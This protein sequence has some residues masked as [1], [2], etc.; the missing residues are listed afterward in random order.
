[1]ATGTKQRLKDLRTE[2]LSVAGKYGVREVKVFGS[3]VRGED[4]EGSDI[5]F[6]VEFSTPPTLVQYVGLQEELQRL[7]GRNVDI[8]TPTSLHWFIREKVLQ[9][10]EPL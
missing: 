3:V 10:A 5:D 2:I 7:L 8:L 6:L 4:S 1:M 9:E